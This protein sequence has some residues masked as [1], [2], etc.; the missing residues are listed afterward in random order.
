MAQVHPEIGVD[1]PGVVA[2][3]GEG[4]LRD[5]LAKIHNDHPIAGPLDEREIVLDDDHGA[6]L[7]G[8]APAAPTDPPAHHRAAAPPPRAR[9]M[10][11]ILCP[12]PTA[13]RPPAA[14]SPT[15]SPTRPPSTGLTPPIGSSRT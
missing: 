11:G 5:D 12:T 8:E 13:G 15:P 2:Q 4:P 7:G 3:A 10:S 9:R 1:R 14:K 6:A